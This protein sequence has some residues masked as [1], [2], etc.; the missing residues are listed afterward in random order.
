MLCFVVLN[1]ATLSG[2][3]LMNG[4]KASQ[5]YGLAIGFCIVVGGSALRVGKAAQKR[6]HMSGSAKV[7]VRY[8]LAVIGYPRS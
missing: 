1:V 7:F 8:T 3:Y 5:I 6:L 2:Q 4:G